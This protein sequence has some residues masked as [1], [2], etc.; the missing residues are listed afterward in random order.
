MRKV[1]Q[2][3]SNLRIAGSRLL[4][5]PPRLWIQDRGNGYILR[6]KIQGIHG[7]EALAELRSR[8][9]LKELNRQ[10]RVDKLVERTMGAV[11][12]FSKSH[13]RLP[14]PWIPADLALFVPWDLAGQ[15]SPGGDR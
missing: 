8:P 3:A 10:L 1:E 2:K 4:V 6:K 9:D 14:A 11:T 15:S 5:N 7:E 12:D 13:L